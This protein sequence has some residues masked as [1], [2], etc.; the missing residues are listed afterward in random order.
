MA[1]V[2]ATLTL[3]PNSV[4]SAT[5]S[6]WCSTELSTC[7]TVCGKS[8]P[9]DLSGQQ[10]CSSASCG[11]KSAAALYTGSATPSVSFPSTSSR[12]TSS[13]SSTARLST[14]TSDLGSAAR[15]TTGPT[16]TPSPASTNARVSG[17]GTA[18]PNAHPGLS[19]AA[20][21]G[22]AVGVILVVCLVIGAFLIWWRKRNTPTPGITL[23]PEGKEVVMGENGM[24]PKPEL[25][26]SQV[27]KVGELSGQDN[28]TSP[29]V[30]EL[31]SSIPAVVPSQ[32]SNTFS[33]VPA[34]TPTQSRKFSNNPHHELPIAQTPPVQS[35]VG[36]QATPDSPQVNMHIPEP[37][38]AASSPPWVN[39]PEENLYLAAAPVPRHDRPL[40]DA[41]ITALEEE[42]RRIDAE[43][44]EARRIKAL[45]DQKLA[46]QKR[47]R[48]AKN[49]K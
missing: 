43:I 27:Y 9:N 44:E 25:G 8:H 46:I 37:R 26:G 28:G 39:D 32:V 6:A 3:D 47:L 11:S 48:E 20:K 35:P 49:G 18:S 23:D 31:H 22:I 36:S 2:P 19:G 29:R 1:A 10:A 15:A 7:S 17:T 42:E 12:A 33:N 4:P 40:S 21:A 45:Q 13:F 14:G 38:A 16:G 41:E 24:I 34:E 30:H 5:R